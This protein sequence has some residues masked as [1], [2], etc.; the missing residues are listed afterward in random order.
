MRCE[1]EVF[2][3]RGGFIVHRGKTKGDFD[4][5]A[6][7]STHSLRCEIGAE[8]ARTPDA[9]RMPGVS[10]PREASGV[11][12]IY[13]RFLDGAAQSAAMEIAADQAV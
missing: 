11:R 12:P 1:T 8:D 6:W 9:S 4:K 3:V 7:P 10:G 5:P 13:R 2:R